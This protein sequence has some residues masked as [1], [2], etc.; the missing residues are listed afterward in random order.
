MY[1]SSCHVHV[2]SDQADPDCGCNFNSIPLISEAA[3]VASVNGIFL[4]IEGE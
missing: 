3:P 2:Y 4:D 1:L